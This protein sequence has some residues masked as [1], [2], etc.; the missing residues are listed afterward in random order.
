[1]KKKKKH[2]ERFQICVSVPLTI[3]VTVVMINMIAT[4]KVLVTTTEKTTAIMVK[5]QPLN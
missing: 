1:M 5:T 3:K 4:I 2:I